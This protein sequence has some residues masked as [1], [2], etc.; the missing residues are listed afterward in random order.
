MTADHQ[1]P[2]GSTPEGDGATPAALLP[3]VSWSPDAES[4]DAPHVSSTAGG[5]LPQGM[6]SATSFGFPIPS[7]PAEEA[8]PRRA[9][10]LLP[11]F[12]AA[13]MGATVGTGATLVATNR[14][15][16][17]GDSVLVAPPVR[18]GVGAQTSGVAAVAEAVRPSIVSIRTQSSNFFGAQQG[19]GSGVIYR[20]DGYILTNNHVVQGATSVEVVL[21]TGDT[22][23]GRVVGTAAPIDDIAVVKVDRDGLP[24]ATLGSVGDIKVGDLAVAIGSPFGLEGTVT[25]GIISALH[26]NREIGDLGITDAI[27]TDAPINPGN[28]GG[29]L[30]D[31]S[32]R[33]IGINTAIVGGAGNVGIGFAIPIDI[34]RTD[35]DQIIQTGR[36][37]RPFLGIQGGNLAG[38]RG[39][40]IESVVSG[41]PAARAGIRAGDIIVAINGEK[42]S[43]MDDL[44]V[45]LSRLKV[46]SEAQIT[47]ERDGTRQTVKATLAPR[48]TG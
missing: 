26:R 35:A 8:A 5:S 34:A 1:E 44:I 18:G 27:Q 10:R 9:S 6:P 4:L 33:V 13:L 28:S 7:L 31:A 25:A 36:A 21:S 32:G 3:P 17:P 42:V 46:G 2:E 11:V 45:R 14:N 48:P 39:A 24:A 22:L 38:N 41:G 40:L 20:S 43:S 19:T 30:V 47:F 12:L 29:A 23:E 15:Q 16:P 37:T